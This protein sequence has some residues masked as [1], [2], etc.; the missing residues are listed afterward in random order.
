MLNLSVVIPTLGRPAVLRETLESLYGCEPL[1]YEVVVVDGDR[2]RSAE[3]VVREFAMR[4]DRLRVRYHAGERGASVQ[5]NVG[6][7]LASGEVVLFTDDDVYFD[8]NVF[9]VLAEAYRDRSVVGA[10]GRI[11]QEWRSFGNEQSWIRRVLS[12]GGRDGSM[13]R[14]GYPRRLQD[15]DTEHDVESMQGCL[16]SARRDLAAQ[17]GFD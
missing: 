5:R 16:M 6:I 14:F 4:A 17:V 11:V 3:Q 2:E 8:R 12:F 1:P 9:G 15:L 7:E 10:T 13:T